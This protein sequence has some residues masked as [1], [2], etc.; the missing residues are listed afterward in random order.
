MSARFCARAP[1]LKYKSADPSSAFCKY[2]GACSAAAVF[3]PGPSGTGSSQAKSSLGSARCDTKMSVA[4]PP[5]LLA[6]KSK[7]PSR[8]RLGAKSTPALLIGGPRF[9]GSDHSELAK[10][11]A[12]TLTATGSDSTRQ[13]ASRTNGA[14]KAALQIAAV[15]IRPPLKRL[16][17]HTPIARCTTMTDVQRRPSLVAVIVVEPLACAVTSPVAE[18]VPTP[19][20]LCAHVTSRPRR[21]WPSASQIAALSCTVAPTTRS[22]VSGTIVTAATG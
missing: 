8:D 2:I 11:M 5:L 3:T 17:L 9:T 1:R 14:S 20:S 12:W 22:V 19:G 21:T 15:V 16:C 13:A 18:T 7:W 4:P 10:D 6:K